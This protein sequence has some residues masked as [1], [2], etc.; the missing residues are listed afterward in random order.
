MKSAQKN[1]MYKEKVKKKTF[2]EDKIDD[3]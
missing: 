1:M 2:F 3:L